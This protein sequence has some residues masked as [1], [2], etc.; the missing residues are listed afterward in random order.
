M[1]GTRP[2]S[3]GV[4]LTATCP[5]TGSAGEGGLTKPRGL[6]SRPASQETPVFLPGLRM[7][8]ASNKKAGGL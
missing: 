6:L 5:A 1:A 8:P 4:P 7:S 2:D 3:E